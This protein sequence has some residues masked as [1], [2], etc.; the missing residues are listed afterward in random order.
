ME[1]KKKNM[2]LTYIRQGVRL[3]RTRIQKILGMIIGRVSIEGHGRIEIAI[4]KAHTEKYLLPTMG[5]VQTKE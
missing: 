4:N 3:I 1:G 5:K 2:Q